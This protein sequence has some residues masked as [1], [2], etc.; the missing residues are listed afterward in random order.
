MRAMTNPSRSAVTRLLLAALIAVA[1]LAQAGA[2]PGSNPQKEAAR[3]A[4]SAPPGDPAPNHA[5]LV[6]L[7]TSQGCSSC[8]PAD[9]LLTKLGVES[10]GRVV[11]LSFHVDIWNHDGWS[12]PFSR[13]EWTQRQ[14]TYARA[15]RLQGLYTPEAVI[16]GRA[17]LVGSKEEGIRNAIA[18]AASRPAA[19][20]ALRFEPADSKIRVIADV[21]RPEALRGR[22]LDL[23][24][25][26]FETDLVTSVKR[27]ENGGQT[28]RNDYVV[29]ILRQVARMS[30]GGPAR[31]QYNEAFPV[32]KGWNRDRLGVAAFLQDPQS[33][34]IHG[35]NAQL[36]SRAGQ[37]PVRTGG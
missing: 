29:R 8:P 17:E 9:R 13:S 12:D 4:A 21:Q 34:E 16:D 5:V 31:A 18:S 35:A 33:L 26:L 36:V 37:S 27:G 20:I 11:P 24:L 10:E 1:A 7:F 22:K 28:L 6:E 32:D 15:F 14:A 25:A 30:A 19:Q 23:M 2:A 3:Q